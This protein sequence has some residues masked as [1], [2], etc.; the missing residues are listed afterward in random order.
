VRKLGIG[1][2]RGRIFLGPGVLGDLSLHPHFVTSVS[3][4]LIIGFQ[5]LGFESLREGQAR[6]RER[7]RE[8][9]SDV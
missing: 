6:E 2:Y 9:K 5:V 3:R 4:D 1:M 7:E 8:R